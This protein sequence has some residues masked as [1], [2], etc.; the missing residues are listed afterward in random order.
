MQVTS[1]GSLITRIRHHKTLLLD[2]VI[3]FV[4]IWMLGAGNNIFDVNGPGYAPP[5]QFL[6]GFT[7]VFFLWKLLAF[8]LLALARTRPAWPCW[9]IP[10]LLLFHLVFFE[11]TATAT[12]VTCY[13]MLL[14]GRLATP[15][16]RMLAGAA[17]LLGTSLAIVFRSEVMHSWLPLLAVVSVSWA[18][19][20]FFWQW[21]ARMRDRDLE[22]KALRDRV[23]L[24][25]I[26][27]R[28]RIAREMH[29]IVAHSLTAI[30]VQA[31][32][33]R[34][35]GKQ[36]PEKAV[37]T[38]NTIASTAR[39]SLEQ[40]RGLLSVLRDGDDED[41]RTSA[42]G[43]DAIPQLISEARANGLQV[44]YL[45]QGT[46][47]PLDSTRELTVYRIL[48]ECLT[49]AIR[50]SGSDH[51]QLDITWGANE[52]VIRAHNQVTDGHSWPR[53]TGRGITGIRERTELHGGRID[54]NNQ[55]GFTVTARIPR[56]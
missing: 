40:M 24:A 42:P 28:T 34:Y 4:L 7:Y 17:A 12:Y 15:Q 50:H 9:G 51:V 47:Y 25:A 20:G 45:V 8:G 41:I 35:I 56:K 43:T 44:D 18:V 39:E 54:I 32:G 22:L 3:A 14:L 26:S 19:L 55:N 52:V 13:I 36:N 23:A 46:P 49:N 2:M 5:W 48:Q 6:P 21:G 11:I 29:D 16:W 33:G 30:I 38:L 10:A 31:D 1:N 53:G 37:E 27:E